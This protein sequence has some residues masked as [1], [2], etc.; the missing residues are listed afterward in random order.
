[1][2][3]QRLA[4]DA[5]PEWPP[6]FRNGP[7]KFLNGAGSLARLILAG[8]AVDFEAAIDAWPELQ[9]Q[10]WRDTD[11]RRPLPVSARRSPVPRQSRFEVTRGCIAA[12]V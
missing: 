3:D 1:V 6:L 7:F 10:T 8:E 9:A 2:P 12:P 4:L 11:Q 5:V